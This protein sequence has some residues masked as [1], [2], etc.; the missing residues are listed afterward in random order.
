M[1]S[2][3]HSHSK[4]CDGKGE[5]AEYLKAAI[6]H[7]IFSIGFSSHA[8]LPFPCKWTMNKDDLS[9]YLEDID[10][11][12]YHHHELEI[13]KSLE[14]DFIPGVVSPFHYKDDLDY[15]I[16]SIHFVDQFPDG[17][18]WEIDNTFEVFKDGL[19]KIFKGNLKDAVCRYLELTREM[20]FASAPDIIGHLD[21]IKMHNG[22]GK[23][24]DESEKWYRD[25][26]EKTL[27]LIDTANLI[28]EVNTRG[29]YKKKSATTYPSPWVLEKIKEKK[30]PITLSSDA[31][32]PDELISDFPEV[33]KALFQQGF[34]Q[35]SVLVEGTWQQLPFNEHG[36]IR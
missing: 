36:I 26:M 14:I 13:Y 32:H 7:K 34:R 5:V 12:R 24:F 33:A 9:S 4:Y 27:K 18:R 28:V 35:L 11:L 3:Y 6:D 16:G 17:K 8:P 30:I 31:H 23:F 15:T 22:E 2:N 10:H 1:W 25:E 21:K 19:D 29:L 20:I